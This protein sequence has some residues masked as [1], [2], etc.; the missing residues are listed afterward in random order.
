MAY[1]ATFPV[2]VMF[3]VFPEREIS[4]WFIMNYLKSALNDIIGLVLER[5]LSENPAV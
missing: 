4:S 2:M 3:K 1:V 5:F